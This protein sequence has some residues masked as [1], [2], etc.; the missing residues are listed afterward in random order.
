MI[1]WTRDPL[2]FIWVDLIDIFLHGIIAGI[3]SYF[4]YL[5]YLKLNGDKA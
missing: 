1:I 2:T 3:V 5:I 4:G